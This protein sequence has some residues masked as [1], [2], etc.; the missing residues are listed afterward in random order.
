LAVRGPVLI[1]AIVVA[2]VLLLV[3]GVGNRSTLP[4]GA[5]EFLSKTWWGDLAWESG[6]VVLGG[7]VVAGFLRIFHSIRLLETGLAD[8]LA[9]R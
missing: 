9:F 6:K 3:F 4:G 2:G 7:G 5:P 1:V 8:F